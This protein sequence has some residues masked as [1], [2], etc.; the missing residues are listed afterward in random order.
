LP[1][2]YTAV[3]TALENAMKTHSPR[4]GAHGK[5]LCCLCDA[6]A[7]GASLDFTILFPRQ[8]ENDVAQWQAIRQAVGEALLAKGGHG[9]ENNPAKP[10]KSTPGLAAL[11]GLKAAL[12]PDGIMNPGKLF[13][14]L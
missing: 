6:D 8:L 3:R 11:R 10:E 4:P 5:V 13:P 1:A 12:D 2:R 7:R 14:P 9:D